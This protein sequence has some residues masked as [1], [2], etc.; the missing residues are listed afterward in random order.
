MGSLQ[1]FI[2]FLVILFFLFKRLLLYALNLIFTHK[3]K[4]EVR[5]GQVALLPPSVQNT[6][7]LFK[8]FTV[9]FDLREIAVLTAIYHFKPLFQTQLKQIVN[10]LEKIL[11][12]LTS[13]FV[14][15]MCVSISNV[16]IVAQLNNKLVHASVNNL[17]LD[18]SILPCSQ[19]ALCCG[20]IDVFSC[21]LL[22]TVATTERDGKVNQQSQFVE[23]RT[24]TWQPCLA[25]FSV[26][27]QTEIHLDPVLPAITEITADTSL[28]IRSG[29]NVV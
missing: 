4:I 28:D 24:K 26:G 8:N 7:F 17:S 27:V 29:T 20:L 15:F 9:M 23:S 1:W 25:E 18:G 2:L 21:R 22:Q 11:P 10:L 3:L 19:I 16:T 5:L 14:Q 12:I 13:L 6:Y